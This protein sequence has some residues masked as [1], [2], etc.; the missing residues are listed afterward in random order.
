MSDFAAALKTVR[1]FALDMDGTF[2]LGNRVLDGSMDFLKKVE[3]TGRQFVFLTNNSSKSR[4]EYLAK[5]AKMGV[6]VTERQM[7]TS[8]Q[9]TILHLQRF[10]PGK[11][12]YLLGNSIL[13]EEFEDAGIVLDD[14][15]PDVL[16][17][18]FDTTLTYEK[19]TK[20]CDFARAGL[21]FLATHP[22]YNC[23]TETGFIP[24]IGAIHAF[25]HA[26]TGRM[27][28]KIIGK[29]YREIIDCALAQTGCRAEETV[30]V[31]DRLYTDIAVAG[32][33]PGLRSILVLSGETAEAD[34]EGAEVCPDMVFGSLKDMIPYLE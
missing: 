16:V 1:C 7:V 19:M 26:S 31:G 11:R 25:I 17:T 24:D 22:D 13:A 33:V 32:N 5:L 23:P 29:P 21:P 27:P 12:V 4:K 10:F 15:N 30:M 2:Y 8:G 9:A 18:A 6:T 20:A 34:L 3:E 14:D 28:D